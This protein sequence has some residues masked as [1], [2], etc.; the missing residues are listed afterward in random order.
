MKYQFVIKRR[1]IRTKVGPVR[2]ADAPSAVE[3][4]S[5]DFVDGVLEALIFFFFIFFLLK[6]QIV[7]VCSMQVCTRLFCECFVNPLLMKF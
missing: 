4:R 3:G 7:F 6:N 1:E 2:S 5:H